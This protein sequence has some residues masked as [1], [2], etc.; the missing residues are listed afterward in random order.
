MLLLHP[1]HELLLLVHVG[2]LLG[3]HE[4]VTHSTLTSHGSEVI[5]HAHPHHLRVL[6]HHHLLHHHLLLHLLLLL[7][8]IHVS[9]IRIE[10]SQVRN[11]LGLLLLFFGLL[12]LLL[13]VS[14][15]DTSCTSGLSGFTLA[16]S[17]DVHSWLLL[18]LL[19]LLRSREAN[20]IKEIESIS[21]SCCCS[22]LSRGASS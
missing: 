6:V 13:G 21:A 2:L 20:I 12:L 5:V 19:L 4:L 3:S 14:I 1:S 8:C 15:K 18:L 16:S 7:H 17:E 9:L 22:W 11:E 10:A